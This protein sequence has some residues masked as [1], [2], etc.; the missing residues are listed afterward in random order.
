MQTMEG[1]AKTYDV[2]FFFLIILRAIIVITIFFSFF[3]L[4]DDF[5]EVDV[6]AL[7]EISQWAIAARNF[8]EC[9]WKTHIMV[10]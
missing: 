1:K 4:M 2:V 9:I 8:A 3:F 7:M 6:I 10:S 5:V